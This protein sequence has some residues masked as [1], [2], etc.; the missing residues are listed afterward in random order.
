MTCDAN[1]GHI[2][3]PAFVCVEDVN[4]LV[5]VHKYLWVKLKYIGLSQKEVNAV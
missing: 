1:D 4:Y 2:E 3:F 5:C